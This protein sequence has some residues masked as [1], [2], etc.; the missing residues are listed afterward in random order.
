MSTVAP[1]PVLRAQ[2]GAR[3]VP[4]HLGAGVLGAV[5]PEL[6]AAAEGD[7]VFVVVDDG[8]LPAGEQVAASCRD[9]G[10]RVHVEAVPAGEALG[11][12]VQEVQV[13]R[14]IGEEEAE[15]EE[16]DEEEEQQ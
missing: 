2:I 9:A 10:M 14:V 11:D 7:G 15:E 6:A 16:E 12:E 1:E 13:E 5:G 3:T 8:V 4:I